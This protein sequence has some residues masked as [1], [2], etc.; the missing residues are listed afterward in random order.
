MSILQDQPLVELLEKLPNA[1]GK[2]HTSVLQSTLQLCYLIL[3]QIEMLDA[4]SK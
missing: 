4:Q 3:E 2:W 1:T